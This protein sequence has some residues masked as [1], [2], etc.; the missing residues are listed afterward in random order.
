MVPDRLVVA[1]ELALSTVPRV[2]MT[3]LPLP[4]RV[5]TPVPP[6]VRASASWMTMSPLTLLVA[7]SV[8]TAVL[9]LAA[10][11]APIPVFAVRVSVPAVET[12]LSVLSPA[13]S[14]GVKSV[15]APSAVSVMAPDVIALAF[16]A[17]VA[18][19]SMFTTAILPPLAATVMTVTVPPFVSAA[20][21]RLSVS[22]RLRL[23]APVIRMSSMAWLG[24]AVAR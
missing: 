18:L 2:V 4:A 22:V 23:P 19:V 1:A 17:R 14:K 5:R 3:M 10:L 8:P 15:T 13:S 16:E 6:I 7:T 24:L 9:R 12:K 20:K 11:T 21:V